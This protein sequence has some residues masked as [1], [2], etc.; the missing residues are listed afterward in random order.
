MT[1]PVR[2]RFLVALLAVI[3]SGVAPT[4]AE[5]KYD[6]N[7]FG[8]LEAR[9]I[10]P[11]VMG[12]R[13]AAL[14]AVMTERLMVY[15][16][17]ASG[18]VWKSINGGITFK[19]VFD[20]YTQSIGAIAMDRKKPETV[21]VGTGEAW[22]RNSVSVGDGV[23]KT[24][25]G[26]DN[27]KHVGLKDT[28]RIV[29]ILIHPAES[30]TVYVCAPGHLWNSNEER[31][32]FK[33]TDGGNIWNKV[34]YVDAD[35]GCGD[36]AMDPQ[37][38]DILYAG[39]W[40]F[41]RW[42]WHF[43][44]GGP[45]SGLYKTTDG[46]TTWKKITSGLPESEL[47]RIGI[48]VAPSRPNR[49]YATVESESTAMYR[50]DDCG[51]SWTRVGTTGMVEARPFYF[52]LVVVDPKNYDRVY[53]PAGVTAVSNDAGETFTNIAGTPHPDH[54]AFWINPAN[55]DHILLGT[56]GGLYESINR[57]VHWTFR[58]SLPLSQFYQVSYD[59][60]DPYYVYG[61]L[62]DNGSWMGPSQ[63]PT[64]ITNSLWR[65]IGGGDG[66]HV[67]VDRG[68]ADFIYTEWQGGHIQ[69]YRRSTGETKDIKPLEEE[70]DPKY[71]FNWNSPIQV[72]P[73]RADTMYIGGQYLFRSRDRGESWEKI[74][75]DLTTNDP[76]KQKQIE[77]GGLTV[78]NSTAENHCTIYTIA[79][80][81]FDENII[82]VGTDDGNVQVTQ[83]GG[84]SWTNV[85][86]NLPDVLP[87]TWVSQV[88]A[89][90]H[91]KATAYVTLDG[92]RTGDMKPYLFKTT[93][94]GRTWRSLITEG[95]E[96]YA[97]SV[98][99]DIV[100]PR[101]LFLG[102]EFGLYISIDDGARWARF[103][104]KLPKVA[105]ASIAIHP[106]EH[107]V[108]LGTH[109]RGIWIIDD[110]TPLRHLSDEVLDS[111]VAFLPTNPAQMRIPAGGQEFSGDDQFVGASRSSAAQITYYLKKR[112]LFGDLK[113]EVLDPEGKV[114]SSLPG[115]RRP[116]INR[117]GWMLRGKPPKVPPAATLVPD[118]YAMLGPQV[119]EGTYK[120]RLVKGDKTY[121]SSVS[122]V[123]DPRA[124]YT[125]EGRDLQD[126][127][128]TQLY[129]MLERLTY[130]VDAILEVQEQ[131][132]ARVTKLTENQSLR[133]ETRKL[134]DD[135]DAF[136][137]TLVA[138]R[139]GGFI[140]GEEQLREKIGSLYGAVNGYEG[141]PTHS[142]VKYLDVLGRQLEIAEKRFDGEFTQQLESLNQKL[143]AAGAEAIRKLTREEW[144][145]KRDKE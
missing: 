31:G 66:F 98:R 95:V 101:L 105:V 108:I 83:N 15:V 109:G 118:M 24:T 78:D 9:A 69:R 88:E 107:D 140:A 32:V 114:L 76:E 145:A 3:G 48:A 89:S 26:G 52:S 12:G 112:H 20:E 28:E 113:V 93:D 104:S 18:G 11:A 71:R 77:S 138:T 57:G 133:D 92:H 50:S 55:P 130:V 97:L 35:T 70:G 127:T 30:D 99:Q 142:Q 80:S 72:S 16:G 59:L 1:S 96:G 45:G 141:G 94:F 53:K 143:Q 91:D 21:W 79:E 125:K 87:C 60:Q 116:G 122:A 25:D 61:G 39:M 42:P 47:G 51:E 75:P 110:I 90:P 62:Q 64:G 14:D 86:S 85:T 5:V 41:R 4:R 111:D 27:W 34:L 13:I 117:V 65:N 120:V 126:K 123:M 100:N 19:A 106:R 44:S 139:K 40:Q 68:A 132:K 33:T 22:T 129:G 131:S 2:L 58:Q 23:Y 54:H 74:S 56:D 136:R 115:G 67:H 63:A 73:N 8:E 38:P 121:E 43:E 144:K 135:L 119:A 81:P 36:L 102:T 82:W 37:E 137:K 17:A 7:T 84:K 10:G 46:G 103:K 49:V 6:S 134:H 124:D 128:V 29:K